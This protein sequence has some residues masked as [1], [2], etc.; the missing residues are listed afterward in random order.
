M[1]LNPNPTYPAAGGYVLRLH[2]DA[3]PA[4]GHLVGR[5]EHVASGDCADY[6]SVEQLLDWLAQHATQVPGSHNPFRGTHEEPSSAV[7]VGRSATLLAACRASRP[8]HEEV[9]PVRTS[10]P[11]ATPGSVGSA[12]SG[13]IVAR[14]E[15]RLGFRTAGKVVARLVDVGSAVNAASR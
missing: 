9:R 6:A 11:A 3:R 8:P 14:Y 4:A 7:A 5:I 1:T 2:R 10:S 13:E 12:Y 15:S